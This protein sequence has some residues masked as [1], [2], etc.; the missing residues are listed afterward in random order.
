MTIVNPKLQNNVIINIVDAYHTCIVNPSGCKLLVL[1][2]IIQWTFLERCTKML[3]SV[4]KK[5]TEGERNTKNV[6]K[7]I[8]AV[9]FGFLFRNCDWDNNRKHHQRN[10]QN[11]LFSLTIQ[12]HLRNTWQNRQ[13]H[14]SILLFCCFLLFFFYCWFLKEQIHAHTCTA[15]IETNEKGDRKKGHCLFISSFKSRHDI[16]ICINSFVAVVKKKASISVSSHFA[17][18]NRD[19]QQI[20]P[21]SDKIVCSFVIYRLMLLK[22]FSLLFVS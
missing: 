9:H 10:N 11:S 14:S 3:S 6:Q 4:Q 12:L 13:S 1:H 15:S 7:I 16:C 22:Y 20:E 19:T 18:S 2:H 5:H 8:A 17:A 21:K